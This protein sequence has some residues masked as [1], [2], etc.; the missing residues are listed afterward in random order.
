[1][2]FHF[3]QINQEPIHVLSLVDYI[4]NEECRQVEREL[5]CLL[6]AGHRHVIVDFSAL[7][8]IT[9]ASLLRFAN[10][11]R[12]F[13]RQNGHLALANVPSSAKRL[14][15]IAK[16]QKLLKPTSALAVA[17]KSLESDPRPAS[18]PNG[19]SLDRTLASDPGT[20]L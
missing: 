6:K 13:R 4:G 17:I 18:E 1:M 2:S 10:Q 11:I 19:A 12:S 5:E 15:R 14:F 9:T 8:F 20:I 7:R 3:Q 16:L